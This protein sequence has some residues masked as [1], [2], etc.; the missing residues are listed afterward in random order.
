[1]LAAGFMISRQ[2][3]LTDHAERESAVT[4]KAQVS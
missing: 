4:A 3:E 2:P 1:M